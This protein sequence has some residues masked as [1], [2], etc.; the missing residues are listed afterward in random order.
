MSVVVNLIVSQAVGLLLKWLFDVA[1]KHLFD[2]VKDTVASAER[3]PLPGKTEDDSPDKD[4]W[5]RGKLED[6]TQEL[7]PHV[8]DW[9]ISTA[10]EMVKKKLIKV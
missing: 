10:V 4:S 5:V 2:K 3:L 8:V 9:L 1:D 6:A 7:K